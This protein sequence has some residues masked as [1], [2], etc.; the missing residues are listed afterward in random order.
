MTN[1]ESNYNAGAGHRAE[2]QK[3]INANPI[4]VDRS[5]F[6]K[7]PE[8]RVKVQTAQSNFKRN[9]LYEWNERNNPGR[10]KRV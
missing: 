1:A 5:V 9:G 8:E 3:E 10:N 4:R 6:F 2:I 7:T